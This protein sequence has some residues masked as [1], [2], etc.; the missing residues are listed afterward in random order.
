MR[1]N[2]VYLYTPKAKSTWP[3]LPNMESVSSTGRKQVTG[4]TGLK[5]TQ[6]Y[7]SLFGFAVQRLCEQH[8]S[9][10][11]AVDVADDEITLDS[12]C[13]D[14]GAAFD[15]WQDAILDGVFEVLMQMS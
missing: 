6:S 1:V 11:A 3:A 5:A 2:W 9:N 15:P 8:Q 14:A 13:P 12:L 4:G 7:P 10:C